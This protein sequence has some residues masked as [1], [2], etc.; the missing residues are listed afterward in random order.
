MKISVENTVH[1]IASVYF[2]AFSRGVGISDDLSLLSGQTGII[3][4]CKHYLY[5]YPNSAWEVLLEEYIE[6]F[7]DNLTSGMSLYTYCA[8]ITGVLD[9]LKYLN[10]QRLLEVDYSDIERH[11]K[12]VLQHFAINN[13]LQENFDYLH[14]GLGVLKYFSHDTDFAQLSL[15]ALDRM[16]EKNGEDYK[17]ISQIGLSQEK[18]YN[19][20]LSHGMS[21]IVSVL[22]L[23]PEKMQMRNELLQGACNYILSQELEYKERGCFFPSVSLE[24]EQMHGKYRSRLAW[25]YGDLGIA[26]ALWQAGKALHDDKIKGK[27][28]RIFR[29]STERVNDEG[30]MVHDAGLCH[31]SASIAMMFHYI[32]E[33]TNDN[34]LRH[35]RDFWI[36]RTLEMATHK[37]GPAGYKIWQGTNRTWTTGYG[38][39]EGIAGIGLLL[40]TMITGEKQAS[41]WMNFFLMS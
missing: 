6:A 19:I 26:S 7:F 21:S 34:A 16:A 14:G 8:G 40:L 3:I 27:A 11:Y 31:G 25:C 35:S 24:Y 10:E 29:Y 23:L 12:P 28:L 36:N 5:V 15:D 37:D 30:N 13:I 9:G 39:L 4:F 32:F 18:G 33:Q 1:K 2:D 41:K 17:W 38:I 22:C 20:S